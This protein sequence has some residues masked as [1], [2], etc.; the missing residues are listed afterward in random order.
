MELTCQLKDR[1]SAIFFQH[2]I[3]L[4]LKNTERLMVKMREKDLQSK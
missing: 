4:K 1:L 2:D 3:I